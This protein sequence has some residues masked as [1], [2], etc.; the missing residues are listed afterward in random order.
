MPESD[1]ELAIS[2]VALLDL[3]DEQRL[4]KEGY[5]L[6]DEK[7][8]LLAAEIRRQMGRL[9]T[10]QGLARSADDKARAALMAALDRHGMDELSVYPPLPLSDTPLQFSQSRLFGLELL[11]VHWRPS[12]APAV[13]RPINPTPEARA[14]AASYRDW[15]ALLVEI[16]ACCVNLR[17]LVLEYV[18]TERRARAIE[19]VLLPEIDSGLKFIEEQLEGLD[20]EEIARLRQRR[21]LPG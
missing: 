10:W 12:A 1:R 5:E 6:L 7:R 21:R 20:Q 19:N 13:K 9:R 18:R 15:L 11:Q 16:A 4:V 2:R 14:C 3:R 8:I 17:R